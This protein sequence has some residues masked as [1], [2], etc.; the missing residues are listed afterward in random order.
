MTLNFFLFSSTSFLGTSRS[1]FFPPT[2]LLTLHE[3]YLY[4]AITTQNTLKWIQNSWALSLF[5]SLLSI[6]EISLYLNINYKKYIENELKTFSLSLSSISSI[7]LYP[8][9]LSL[10]SLF[11]LSSLSLLCFIFYLSL[12]WIDT[13]RAYVVW[14]TY[15]ACFLLHYHK[16]N[17]Q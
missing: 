12:Y 5:L 16:M 2:I 13:T 17:Q 14:N 8:Y 6:H 4:F 9:L 15:Q 11:Y 10:L 7:Y 3:I 1:Y